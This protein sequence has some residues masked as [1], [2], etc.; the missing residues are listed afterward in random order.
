MKVSVLGG[1]ISG[2]AAAFLFMR[3]GHD[4]TI[5]SK[6]LGGEFTKG[7]LKY[8]HYTSVVDDFLTALDI[9]FQVKKVIGAL[10]LSGEIYSYP[11]HFYYLGYT[12][13]VEIQWDFYK[14]TRE[15]T[16]NDTMKVI[17]C[18]ND[19]WKYREHLKVETRQDIV[20]E[21]QTQL[22]TGNIQFNIG[23]DISSKD[24]IKITGESDLSIY[25]LPLGLIASAHHLDIEAKFQKLLIFRYG[26]KSG[27]N[28]LWWDYLYEPSPEWHHHRIS[29]I[30]YPSHGYIDNGWLD[31]EVNQLDEFKVGLEVEDQMYQYFSEV[32]P[33]LEWF[34]DQRVEIKG[35]LLESV[36]IP[37]FDNVYLLGRYATWDSRMTFDKVLSQLQTYGLFS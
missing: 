18:M 25:T 6:T 31:V 23:D 13:S 29:K 9:D 21:L 5:H 16:P 28:K 7:G 33:E 14:K 34:Y 32:I 22:L 37:E 4:V 27:L 19:P 35:H 17:S 30:I 24:V 3:K 20:R 1:G 12:D 8:I 2:M 10:H 36:T 15:Q 11:E 26:V